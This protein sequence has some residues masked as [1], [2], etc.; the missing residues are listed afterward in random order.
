MKVMRS[1]TAK[2]GKSLLAGVSF[3]LDRYEHD[4]AEPE[5]P[6]GSLVDVFKSPVTRTRMVLTFN[7]IHLVGLWC[8]VLW[9][10]PERGKSE[11]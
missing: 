10:K 4:L 11:Y 8:G 9:I 5:E 1:I 3:A 2:N 7:G 6:S